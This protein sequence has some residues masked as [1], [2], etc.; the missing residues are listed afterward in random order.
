MNTA[1]LR[2][3]AELLETVDY[4]DQTT[5]FKGN[6]PTC[7]TPACALGHWVANHPDTWEIKNPHYNK[8]ILVPLLLKYSNGDPLEDA[9]TEFE[10]TETEAENLFGGNGCGGAFTGKDAAQFIRDVLAGHVDISE[11][12]IDSWQSSDE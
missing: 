7:A 9:A 3:L 10:L 6:K 1:K 8:S 4:Y 11:E 5:F 2:Q 12:F